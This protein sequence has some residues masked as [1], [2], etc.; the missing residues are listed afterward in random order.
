M[1]SVPL[2]SPKAMARNWLRS[3]WI[4][5]DSS[6][7][8]ISVTSEVK[9]YTRVTWPMTPLESTTACPAMILC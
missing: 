3:I 8:V 6:L 7:S 5:I 9:G 4:G 1:S 2:P